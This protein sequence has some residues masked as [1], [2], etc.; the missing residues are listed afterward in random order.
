MGF[1][2]WGLM[3][4]RWRAK[5]EL[6]GLGVLGSTDCGAVVRV[7]SSPGEIAKELVS[8]HARRTTGQILN[9]R[10]ESFAAKLLEMWRMKVMSVCL[11]RRTEL[12]RRMGPAS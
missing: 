10:W 2:F 1:L 5:L 11:D 9:R 4:W 12:Q 3:Q 6:G 8:S 7:R